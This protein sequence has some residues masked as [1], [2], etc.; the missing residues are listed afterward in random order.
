MAVLP[1]PDC[2]IELSSGL[3]PRCMIKPGIDGAG[4]S[5]AGADVAFDPSLRPGSVMATLAATIGV[6]PHVLLRETL[7]S[8]HPSPIIS[9]TPDATDT[10]LR[11]RIDGE[12]ARG[13]MGAVLRGRDPDL[14]RDVAIKVLREDLRDNHDL[15]RRFV[16]EAPTRLS[17]F[18]VWLR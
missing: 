11:Y 6:V 13:G 17:D 12:I 1:C 15:V 7:P 10:T 14:G 5:D 4:S 3:C 2:G 9:P 16:E 8:E 18:Y